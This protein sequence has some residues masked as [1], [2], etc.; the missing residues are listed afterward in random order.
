L[1]GIVL[2]ILSLSMPAWSQTQTTQPTSNATSSTDQNSLDYLQNSV[3]ALQSGK[4]H[5]TSTPTFTSV[6]FGDGTCQ[7]TAASSGGS[8]TIPS[9]STLTIT[10]GGYCVGIGCRVGYSSGTANS[11]SF[12]FSATTTYQ[13]IFNVT[14]TSGSL[15]ADIIHCTINGDSTAGHFYENGQAYPNAYAYNNNGGTA[16]WDFCSCGGG[17]QSAHDSCTVSLVLTS[18]TSLPN[19]LSGVGLIRNTCQGRTIQQSQPVSL[20]YNGSSNPFTITCSAAATGVGIIYDALLYQT[21]K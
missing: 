3:S 19:D 7:T 17:T 20:T 9:G 11:F 2:A 21:G 1:K 4:P 12:V 18:D 13:F 6:C 8:Q 10:Q 5:F 15:T 14:Q 16:R